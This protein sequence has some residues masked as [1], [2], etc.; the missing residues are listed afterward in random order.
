MHVY[1]SCTCRPER[2]STLHAVRDNVTLHIYQ[3]VVLLYGIYVSMFVL[4]FFW[5][6]TQCNYY[7]RVITPACYVDKIHIVRKTYVKLVNYTCYVAMH[8]SLILQ[9]RYGFPF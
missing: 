4:L 5:E 1:T 3:Y 9:E 8:N 6:N 7:G 2:C